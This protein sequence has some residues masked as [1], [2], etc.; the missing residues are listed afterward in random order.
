MRD[1]GRQKDRQRWER[2]EWASLVKKHPCRVKAS[3]WGF[4]RRYLIISHGVLIGYEYKYGIIFSTSIFTPSG[5]ASPEML[6]VGN[7]ISYLGLKY[8]WH[9][10]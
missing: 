4:Y 5:F 9:T 2:K 10:N 7:C 8:R 3:P 6:L 1:S